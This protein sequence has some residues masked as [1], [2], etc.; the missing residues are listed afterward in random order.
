MYTHFFILATG[1]TKLNLKINQW[2]NSYLNF[3]YIELALPTGGFVTV[4]TEL[5]LQP[6][7]NSSFVVLLFKGLIIINKDAQKF[8]PYLKKLAFWL[9]NICSSNLIP[10]TLCKWIDHLL[11]TKNFI[12][13][14]ILLY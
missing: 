8:V 3:N 7:T 13:Y 9:K 11:P 10:I 1:L 5:L 14:W 4:F 6:F 2:W 12:I